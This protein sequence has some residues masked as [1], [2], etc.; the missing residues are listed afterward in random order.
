MFDL[1]SLKKNFPLVSKRVEL[2]LFSKSDLTENYISWLNNPS[3]VRYSNQRFKKHSMKSCAEYLQSFDNSDFL[4]LAIYIKEQAT[5]IGTMTIYYNRHHDVA[6]I[7]IM[8]GDN[9]FW[10]QGLG[11]ECWQQVLNLLMSSSSIR[12]ITGGTLSCNTGMI[13]I[14]ESTGML[15]DGVRVAQEMVNDIPYDIQY[16]SVLR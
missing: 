16:F 5:M 14:M 4:F 12:K 10:G 3:V 7:G 15:K 8:L 6:D 13:R 1:T 2:R 11:K 9:Q